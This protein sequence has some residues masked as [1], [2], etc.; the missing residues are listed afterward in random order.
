MYHLLAGFAYRKI[1]SYHIQHVPFHPPTSAHEV[2]RMKTRLQRG[3]TKRHFSAATVRRT[4][5]DHAEGKI[6]RRQP[7]FFAQPR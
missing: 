7:T 5:K 2:M 1:V 3:H 6:W 4:A